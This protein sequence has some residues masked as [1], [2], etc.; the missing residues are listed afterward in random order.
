MNDDPD[1][2][3]TMRGVLVGVAIGVVLWLLAGALCVAAL[4]KDDYAVEKGYEPE[5][6]QPEHKDRNEAREAT[7]A[8]RGYRF[9]EGR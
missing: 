5:G 1:E 9:I 3:D 8:G 2:L 6:Y 4:M 7:K